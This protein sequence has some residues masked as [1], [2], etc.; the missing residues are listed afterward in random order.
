[1]FRG[2]RASGLRMVI[3]ANPATPVHAQNY[4]YMMP[5][6]V[7]GTTV[8]RSLGLRGM[9]PSFLLFSNRDSHKKEGSNAS[10]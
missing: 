4:S 3:L 9:I 1:M 6:V 10:H 7:Q 5:F 2:L 8:D